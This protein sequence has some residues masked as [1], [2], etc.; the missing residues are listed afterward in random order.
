LDNGGAKLLTD[1]Y[2]KSVRDHQSNPVKTWNKIY[3]EELG[4]ITAAGSKKI[5]RGQRCAAMP[6]QARQAFKFYRGQN[7]SYLKS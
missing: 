2:F 6:R 3:F 7:L 5:M 4:L 1:V